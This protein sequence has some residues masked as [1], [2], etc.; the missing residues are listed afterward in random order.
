MGFSRS[1]VLLYIDNIH[2]ISIDKIKSLSKS[3]GLSKEYFIHVCYSHP[4]TG[5]DIFAMAYRCLH[6]RTYVFLD[7]FINRILIIYIVLVLI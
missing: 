4:C 7:R 5:P 2:S 3:S 6:I 1:V